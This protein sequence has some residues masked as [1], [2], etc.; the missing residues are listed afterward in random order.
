MMRISVLRNGSKRIVVLTKRDERY[1]GL[2][3]KITCGLFLV[4]TWRGLI[5]LLPLNAMIQVG[6][7]SW[8][9][10][11]EPVLRLG[12]AKLRVLT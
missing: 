6:V 12:D 1:R 11:A 9:L 10:L 7:S 2:A 4:M 5:L 8:S 3:K